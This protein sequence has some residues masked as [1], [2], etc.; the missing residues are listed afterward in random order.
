MP[1]SAQRREKEMRQ[2]G[3]EQYKC[4]K[5]GVKNPLICWQSLPRNREESHGFA[6]RAP[7]GAGNR[8]LQ[9]CLTGEM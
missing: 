4:H 6:L 2:S 3:T 5:R 9:N 7:N 1:S 8:E